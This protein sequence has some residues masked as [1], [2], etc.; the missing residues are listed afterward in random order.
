MTLLLTVGLLTVGSGHPLV[1]W[2]YWVLR[3]PSLIQF[4][5]KVMLHLSLL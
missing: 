3:R 1:H 2:I 4:S 5:L